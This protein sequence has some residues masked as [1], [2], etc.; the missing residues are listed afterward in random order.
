LKN[1][2]KVEENEL[3]IEMKKNYEII[4]KKGALYEN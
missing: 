3:I 2:F 1:K 4:S